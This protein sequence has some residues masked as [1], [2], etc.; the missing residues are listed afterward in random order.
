MNHT[1]KLIRQEKINP[2]GEET[3]DM[4][5]VQIRNWLD[6]K[7]SLALQDENGIAADS[8]ANQIHK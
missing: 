2:R 8:E 7:I 5:S 3:G 4:S 6:K 1:P